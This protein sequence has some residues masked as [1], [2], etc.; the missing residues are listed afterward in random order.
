[1]MWRSRK[2]L[3]LA[4]DARCVVHSVVTDAAGTQGDLKIYGRALEIEEADERERYGVAL[5][6]S[7]DW[8]PAGDFH[9]FRIDVAQA[10]FVR[11][12]P[13]A[14]ML[15]WRPGEPAPAVEPGPNGG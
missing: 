7:L 14:A 6:M 9:L 2:A 5:A 10:G 15:R 4:R 11:A 8:R 13:D 1:M 3:D 12:G